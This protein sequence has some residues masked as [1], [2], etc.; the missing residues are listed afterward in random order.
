VLLQG[1]LGKKG[2]DLNNEKKLSF[3]VAPPEKK[4]E[5]LAQRG[6]R[7]A[8]HSAGGIR[9]NTVRVVRGVEKGRG[10]FLFHLKGR[11]LREKKGVFRAEVRQKLI[12]SQ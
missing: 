1:S 2:G 12:P 5:T 4:G 6:R 9:V 10:L 3:P 7:G 8:S 11:V